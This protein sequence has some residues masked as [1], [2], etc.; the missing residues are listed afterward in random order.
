[1]IPTT[2][3]TQ[4][5]QSNPNGNPLEFPIALCQQPNSSSTPIESLEDT[6]IAP[7][8][9]LDPNQLLNIG[10]EPAAII[11]SIAVIILALAELIKV[12]VPVMQKQGDH[13]CQSNK[14]S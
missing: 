10:G 11:L 6:A 2:S 1:M 12:F 5:T 4:M 8:E 3:K 7:M 14:S 9:P 13:C